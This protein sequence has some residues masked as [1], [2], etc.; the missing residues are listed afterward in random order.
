MGLTRLIHSYSDPGVTL[1]YFPALLSKW[2]LYAGIAA[3]V[4]LVIGVIVAPILFFKCRNR[5]PFSLPAVPHPAGNKTGLL[6][7]LADEI[8]QRNPLEWSQLAQQETTKCPFS[9]P[10][11]SKNP[12]FSSGSDERTRE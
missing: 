2:W 8:L 3:V 11:S 7:Q 12:N 6:R 5:A 9:G 1:V 10:F 4:L